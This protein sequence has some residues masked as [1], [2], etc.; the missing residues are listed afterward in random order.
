MATPYLQTKAIPLITVNHTYKEQ[1]LFPKDIVSGGCVASGTE[2]MTPEGTKVVEDF[3]VGER[4]ITLQGEKVVSYVWNPDT[5]DEGMPECY[6]IEFED[7]YKVVCS[8]EHKF[9]IDGLW[10]EAKNLR[11]GLNCEVV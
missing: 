2:I 8:D 7:G 9:L 1:A 3:N 11:V 10:V 4:V 6:E 5:L